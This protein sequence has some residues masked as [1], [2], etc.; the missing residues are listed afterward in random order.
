MKEERV[1]NKGNYPADWIGKF[2]ECRY[3]FWMWEDMDPWEPGGTAYMEEFDNWDRKNRLPNKD[4]K[5]EYVFIQNCYYI[6][7]ICFD[8]IFKTRPEL[9]P[10]RDTIWMPTSHVAKAQLWEDM[11]KDEKDV[12]ERLVTNKLDDQ[13]KLDLFASTYEM[14]KEGLE[15]IIKRLDFDTKEKADKY[16]S[17]L[18]ERNKFSSVDEIKYEHTVGIKEPDGWKDLSTLMDKS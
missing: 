15:H 11:S 10:F 7:D 1:R 17:H 3:N 4:H 18:M 16:K 14:F 13:M 9:F 5:A 8:D 12:W 6:L 2:E